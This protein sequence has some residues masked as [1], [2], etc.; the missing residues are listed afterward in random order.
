MNQNEHIDDLIAKHL[1]QETST[2][3]E[4]IVNDW[5][6]RSET[7]KMYYSE[8]KMIH[9]V[10]GAKTLQNKI[11]I[12]AAWNKF[13]KKRFEDLDEKTTINDE[14]SIIKKIALSFYGKA[15]LFI[16]MAGLGYSLYS[17]W[18][19]K[20]RLIVF[21]SPVLDT[22]KDTL[23][24]GTFV[25]LNPKSSI[26]YSTSFNRSNRELKLA[27]EGYFHV[28]HNADLPF[29]I[30]TGSIF[31]KDVGTS[32]TIKATP[33]DSTVMVH[34]DEGEVIFYSLQN[35]GLTL[36]KNETGIYNLISETF[37]KK[38][39][40][41]FDTGTDKILS[42]ENTSLRFV[43]DSVNKVYNE[44]I[45]L[46]CEK[47]ESLELTAEFKEKTATP[48]IETIAETFDLS[49]T[50]TNGTVSLNSKACKK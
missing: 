49:I 13:R 10:T 16:A 29:I 36:L 37:R 23:P 5:I 18:S 47:L 48:I 17:H 40:D 12:D 32:F 30:N 19:G 6:V 35:S 21:S 46:S 34:V 20:E 42:F 24:D 43:I 15:A 50:R 44:H 27:G 1:A 38:D 8:M 4:D 41:S 22:R 26:T 3:E 33:S 28:H 14:K 31:V 11:D 39:N 7:N 9:E 2:A 25:L 45:V